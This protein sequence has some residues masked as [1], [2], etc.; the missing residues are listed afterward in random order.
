MRNIAALL[1]LG[2]TATTL[3]TLAACGG[4]DAP[5]TEATGDSGT[6]GAP[7]TAPP[8]PATDAAPVA[9]AA[10]PGPQAVTSPTSVYPGQTAKLDGTPSTGSGTLTYAWT[11]TGT[12]VGST[13]TTGSLTGAA[14]ATPS[15][16]PDKLGVYGLE[17]T[18]TSNGLTS[19]AQT[20]ATVV[21]PPVFLFET[22]NDAGAGYEARIEVIG[23]TEGTTTKPVACFRTDAGSYDTLARRTA[24]AGTDWWEAPAAEASPVTFVFDAKLDG[25]GATMLGV[26]SSSSTCAV[27]PKALDVLP[28]A[29]DTPARPFEQPRISPDGKRV[30]YARFTGTEGARVATVGLDGSNPRILG[31]RYAEADGGPSDAGPGS[32]PGA[33]PIWIDGDTVAW[34]QPL[35]GSNWQVVRADDVANAATQLVVRC[36]GTIP[37]EI[38][39][40]PNGDVVVVRPGAGGTEIVAFPVDAGTKICGAP[41]VLHAAVTNTNANDMALSPDKTRVAYLAQDLNTST[42]DVRVVN[43]DGSSPPVTVASH[44]TGSARGP[45]WVGGG[46]YLTWGAPAA[47][48]DA[49]A[50]AAVG[51]VAADGGVARAAALAPSGGTVQAIGNGVFACGIG[52]AAGSGATLAGIAGVL[53]LRLVRR[54]RR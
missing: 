4:D 3:L 26:A 39:M 25:G 46:A 9:D 38:E 17:L 12:P 20:T 29:P 47:A 6:T 42:V 31:A 22:E 43:V 40:L 33:R 49:G 10:P 1:S 5:A 44:G 41:R 30:A 16:V 7:T 51:V 35:D 45:R 2:L 53:A 15:F 14:T 27:A 23:A 19:K 34:L 8:P 11:V 13:I 52:H 37:Q 54:R 36:T 32:N 24:T 21:D 48:F 18:V 28:G 50:G